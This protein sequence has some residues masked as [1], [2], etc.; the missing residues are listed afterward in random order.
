MN[1][2]TNNW[3][4]KRVMGIVQHYNHENIGIEGIK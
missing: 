2:N 4:M 1:I 3:L